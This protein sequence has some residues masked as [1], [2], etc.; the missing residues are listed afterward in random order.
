MPGVQAGVRGH[1]S[2]PHEE[3]VIRVMA[4]GTLCAN[5]KPGA[6]FLSLLGAP[7]VGEKLMPDVRALGGSET[8]PSRGVVLQPGWCVPRYVKVG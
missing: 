7:D 6:L 1:S 2:P 5:C 3:C 4:E 8:M